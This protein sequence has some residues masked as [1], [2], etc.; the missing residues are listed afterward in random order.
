MKKDLNLSQP[1]LLFFKAMTYRTT[2]DGQTAS[3]WNEEDG[4]YY[5]AIS[6]GTGS[7]CQ[8]PIRSLVGLIPLYA[9]IVI[10][11]SQIK[12]FPSFKK[13]MDWFVE[14]RS[15][16]AQRNMSNIRRENLINSYHASNTNLSHL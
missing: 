13:R 11:P 3:L 7:N 10:E 14:N 6:W 16:L 8:I 5:D 12:Q 15:E 1:F 9:T 2:D 4:F